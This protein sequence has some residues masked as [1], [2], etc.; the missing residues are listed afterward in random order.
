MTTNTPYRMLLP[1]FLAIGS[2]LLAQCAS[3]TSSTRDEGIPVQA[4]TDRSAD[5]VR[6]DVY[7]PPWNFMSL[8]AAEVDLFLREHPTY[9]GRGVLLLILDTGVDMGIPGLRKTSTGEQKVVDAL[10]FAHSNVVACRKETAT[11]GRVRGRKELRNIDSIIPAPMP[12]EIY[13]GWIDEALYRNSSV[14]DFDGD[15]SSES[16]FGLLLYRSAEGWRIVVDTD[17]DGDL[18]DETPI[19]SYRERFQTFGFKQRGGGEPTLTIAASID[20]AARRVALH[21]DM[22]GHG[23]HV[24][25]IAAGFGINGEPGFNGVAPGAQIISCKFSGDTAHDNT[26][27]GS[28]KRAYDYAARL[29]DSL[30]PLHMPVV[31]NMSFGIGSAYEGRGEVEAYLD[32]LIPNHPNLFVVTSAGNEGPGISTV[33]LPAAA[34]R[35]ISVGALLPKGIGRDGYNA[36]IDRDI[37]WD[38]SSRGGEVDKPDVVA[39]GTAVSTV[40][41]F[42]YDPEASGTSMASPYTAGVVALLLSAMRQEDS[43]RMPT[44]EAVRRALR[45]GAIPLPDYAAIE[46]GGGLLNVRRSY[47]ILR[48]YRARGFTDNLQLYTI[49]TLSPNYPDGNGSTAFWRSGFVPGDDWRQNFRISRYIP[50]IDGSADQ[51]F[52]RA[53][54]LEST[55]EWLSTVQKTVYIRN[56][57]SAEVDVMY[58]PSKMTDPGIYS[59]RVVARRAQASGPTPAS[60]VEFELLNTVIVPYR[61]DAANSYRIATPEYLLPAGISRRFYIAPP[62]GASAI[63]F[64]L[65]VPKGT[66]SQVSGKIA[67]RQGETVAYLSRAYGIERDRAS[68]IVPIETLGDGVIEVVVQAEAFD[69]RGGIS[70]FSFEAEAIMLD[71]TV[72]LED[73]GG[74]WSIFVNAYNTGTEPIEGSFSYTIKG[75]GRT[76][77]DTM[78]S[79][80]WRR[81]MTM[82]PDD[83]ALW[84]RVALSEADYMRSTDVLVQLVDDGGAVQAQESLNG[85]EAWLFLP[86]FNRGDTNRYHLRIQYAAAFEG[87]LAPVAVNITENHVH[88]AEPRSLGGFGGS[89]IYPYLPERIGSRLPPIDTPDGY[90]T[91]IDIT[92]KPRDQEESITWELVR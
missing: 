56:R 75:Y 89:E 55:A 26:V 7:V 42:S 52:F 58:D 41:R 68:V 25:G 37:I 87:K 62:A 59:S 35:I 4:G 27:T 24:A 49:S 36:S 90:Q 9:D 66:R 34:S 18:A 72:D 53:Y 5:T 20:T 43:S 12:G 2:L 67:S 85:L 51:D 10:D 80:Q 65:A 29:A 79:D 30:A 73:D 74:V 31:A 88:P 63:R 48:D 11:A 54:T 91:L 13:V 82:R 8:D 44:Q 38:F 22:G 33:G 70:T 3:S 28:M 92:F 76:F 81:T 1:F 39:P 16:L 46:Q 47:E 64:T 86:N 60:E 84:V 83:G 71:A 15:G 14:R 32:T 6:S 78:T 61:F 19:T 57:S 17:G 21:Y 45:A 69:G 50:R 77:S 40:P 23:T